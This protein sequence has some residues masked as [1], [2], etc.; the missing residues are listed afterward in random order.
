MARWL[1]KQEPSTYSYDRL[2][3]DRS[4]EWDGVHNALA[5]RHLRGMARGD[6]A[7]FYHSG[8]ER[9]AV[10]I[11]RVAGAPHPDP[12]DDRGSWSVRVE[13]VR[14]LARPVTLAELREVPGL[15]G[16]ALL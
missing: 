3:K 11:L 9:A 8:D 4:T 16:L 6:E 2:E 13:P 12:K 7:F 1:V 10:G 14:R 5:L 15:A